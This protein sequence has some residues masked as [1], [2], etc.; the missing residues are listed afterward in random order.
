MTVVR[1]ENRKI[2]SLQGIVK[3]LISPPN[4]EVKSYRWIIPKEG[5][6]EEEEVL[7]KG[8]KREFEEEGDIKKKALKGVHLFKTYESDFGLKKIR[9]DASVREVII[10]FEEGKGIEEV[11]EEFK[12]FMEVLEGEIGFKP[13][14]VSFLHYKD[15]RYHVH[16]LLSLK[17]PK[18]R[19]KVNLSRGVWFRILDRFLDKESKKELKKGKTIGN[20]PL[21]L[22]KKIARNLEEELKPSEAE[23]VAKELVRILRKLGV[24]KKLVFEVAKKG[25]KEILE[26]YARAKKKLE[27]LGEFEET[28]KGL[29]KE[30]PEE[31]QEVDYGLETEKERKGSKKHGRFKRL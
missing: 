1:I 13:F 6:K 2:Q 11:R 29:V 24:K 22:V 27:E 31:T 5:I 21:W 20:I 3:H 14:G 8:L 30:L 15:G 18:T 26:V 9:K 12:R 10:A 19:K 17:N 25:A 28:L 16:F 7:L 23:K 4:E